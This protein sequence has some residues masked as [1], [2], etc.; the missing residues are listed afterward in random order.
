MKSKSQHDL[1]RLLLVDDHTL[2]RESLRR[3]LE[4][5]L[6][7]ALDG[8]AL[9][10]HFQPK[11]ASDSLKIVGFEALARWRHPTV[12]PGARTGSRHSRC[13]SWA[14]RGRCSRR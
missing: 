7:Q 10:V 3:L 12:P 6:H 5:E 4:S 13:A 14:N 2:F 11:F 1:I 8:E 9:E